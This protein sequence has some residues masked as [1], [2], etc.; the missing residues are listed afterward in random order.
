MTRLP[1]TAPLVD[2]RAFL[3]VLRREGEIVDIETEVD[4]DLETRG[5]PPP[6]HRRRRAGAAVPAREG[7]AVAARHEPLRHEAPRRARVRPATRASSSRASPRC[8]TRDAAD[9]GKL[10]ANATWRGRCCAKVGVAKTR[11]A[12]RVAEVVATARRA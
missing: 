2:L 7:L 3:A 8:R 10:W 5:D 11:G 4:P 9:P 1:K 12:A 6:R